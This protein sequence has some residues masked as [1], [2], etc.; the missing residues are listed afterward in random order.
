MDQKVTAVRCHA[1]GDPAEVLRVEQ[2]ELPPLEPNQVLV[3]MKAAPVNPADINV[4]QGKYGF[5]PRLPAVCG[6][7]GVG[8]VQEM[9]S[10]VKGLELGQQVRPVPGVGSWCEMLVADGERLTPLP[11]GLTHEQAAVISVNAATAWRMLHDFVEL[12]P[13][14]WVM[15]NAATSAVGKYIIQLASHLGLRT[16][17]VVRRP[18]AVEELEALGGDVVLTEEVK[19]SKELKGL[20]VRPAL[21]LNAVS[22]PSAV[23]LATCLASRGTLVT[24]GA[25]SLKP[26]R[27]P[28]GLLIFRE[29]RLEGFWVTAWY[30]RA[31]PEQIQDMFLRLVPLFAGGTL[32]T[33]IQQ[34]YPLKDAREA[35]EHALRGGRQGKI[36]LEML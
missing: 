16:I 29:L 1:W 20:G 14:D 3:Q 4:I 32:G 36:L 22:G 8:V 35:V 27:I 10:A 17:N 18:E 24:Y 33:F 28:N 7:E 5:L 30:G 13:G 23:N 31:T 2:V 26:L 9:G 19:L 25:M 11:P 34:R 6:N 15:Q 21:A 12:R